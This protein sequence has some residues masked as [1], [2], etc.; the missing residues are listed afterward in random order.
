VAE[1]IIAERGVRKKIRMPVRNSDMLE[2]LGKK[3]W[4]QRS[5]AK[6]GLLNKKDL[7]ELKSNGAKIALKNSLT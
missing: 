4:S 6:K 1:K 2:V 3:R 7:G 5:K